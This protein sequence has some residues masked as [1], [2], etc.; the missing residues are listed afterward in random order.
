MH[1]IPLRLSFTRD[2]GRASALQ[3]PL[4][5]LQSDILPHVTFVS[6]SIGL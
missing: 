6:I 3:P 2:L 5:C 1:I 4:A